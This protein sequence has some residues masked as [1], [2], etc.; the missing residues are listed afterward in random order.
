MTSATR[1]ENTVLRLLAKHGT[2]ADGD[3]AISVD[4]ALSLFRNRAGVMTYSTAKDY[5][6]AIN[7]LNLRRGY[8]TLHEDHS[9]RSQ[10]DAIEFRKPPVR[11]ALPAAT[12]EIVAAAINRLNVE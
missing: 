3:D 10:F 5:M 12:R 9:F 11:A 4:M 1:I 8:G 2:P 7:R 6:F